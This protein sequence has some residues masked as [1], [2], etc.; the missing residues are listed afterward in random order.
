M[1]ISKKYSSVL[2]DNDMIFCL[3]E[4]HSENLSAAADP[5]QNNP[6]TPSSPNPQ[7]TLNAIQ[8]R[9]RPRSPLRIKHTTHR[10]KH[11]NNFIHLLGK[12]FIL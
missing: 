6:L 3:D 9:P 11:V 5:L 10:H 8:Q 7:A 1:K 2:D 12:K 4:D